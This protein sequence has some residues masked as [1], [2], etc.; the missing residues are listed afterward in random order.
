MHE[1]VEITHH[2]L[3]SRGYYCHLY[4]EDDGHF[5]NCIVVA[6]WWCLFIPLARIGHFKRDERDFLFLDHQ[7]LCW[8]EDGEVVVPGTEQFIYDIAE[9]LSITTFEYD[10][11][12]IVRFRP[13][14]Y[15]V[16]SIAV[17]CYCLDGFK[18][19]IIESCRRSLHKLLHSSGK[20]K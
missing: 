8:F 7:V 11:S 6:S 10:L 17:I 20:A 3:R 14:I 4:D 15:G 5:S 9:P 19:F 18:N 1:I 16:V 13:V 12:R 2:H